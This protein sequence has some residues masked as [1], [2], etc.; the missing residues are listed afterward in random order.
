MRNPSC[1]IHG[2]AIIAGVAAVMNGEKT[3]TD[4]SQEHRH[5]RAGRHQGERRRDALDGGSV[6][7]LIED[8]CEE[9]RRLDGGSRTAARTRR[10]ISQVVR[11]RAGPARRR[12]CA[13]R[14]RD[15]RPCRRERRR[16]VH[17]DE[18]H[19]RRPRRLSRAQM[20][21]DGRAVH[22]RSARDAL[23]PASAWF[24]R[25]FRSRQISPSPK[26]SSSACSR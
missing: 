11:R 13:R 12:F 3:G 1:R 25:S 26:M 9:S 10:G 16:Q 15:P 7:D 6:P 5:R 4:I 18:D 8:C 21:V 19:R 2:G 24:I 23:P 14:R 20:R 22:F 17:A